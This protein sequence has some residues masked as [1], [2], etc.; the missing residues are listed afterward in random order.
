M[1]LL[2]YCLFP[3]DVAALV[4][5]FVHITIVRRVC[6]L[7]PLS[8]CPVAYSPSNPLEIHTAHLCVQLIPR[9]WRHWWWVVLAWRFNRAIRGQNHSS[10]HCASLYAMHSRP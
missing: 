7:A 8:C 10:L 9:P 5:V 4:A 2:G 6:A 3:I 1:C